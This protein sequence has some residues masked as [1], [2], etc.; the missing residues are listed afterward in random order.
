MI[1]REVALK[2]L[3]KRLQTVLRYWRDKGGEQL[4]CGW[5]DFQLDELP[6]NLVPTTM[7]V[8][9]TDEVAKNSFRFWGSGMN[10]I[11]GA[12]MTGKTTS[13]LSPP[14]FREAVQRTH[15]MLANQPRAHAT[16]YGFER[17]GGFE[18]MQTV[19]R[20]P[21]SDDGR[22]VSQIVIVLEWTPLGRDRVPGAGRP[23]VF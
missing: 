15:A 14:E 17:Y 21:L 12:D 4:R 16:Y 10:M 3:P 23:G 6:L 5:A 13:E 22:N 11:H 18:H 20:L 9:V 8:D 7:V 2:D 1:E 19:L